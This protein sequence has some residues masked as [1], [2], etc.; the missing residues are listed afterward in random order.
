MERY[1]LHGLAESTRKTYNSAKRRYSEFA[2]KHGFPGKIGDG[3][4][5]SYLS[6]G[7]GQL[8][9]LGAQL[10]ERCSNYS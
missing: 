8:T 6:S 7:S 2:A 1:F 4:K 10:P 5:G 3:G 9:V